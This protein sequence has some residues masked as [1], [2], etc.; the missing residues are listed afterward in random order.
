MV[1]KCAYSNFSKTAIEVRTV[2]FLSAICTNSALTRI[3]AVQVHPPIYR[4]DC[5][6]HHLHRAV[7]VASPRHSLKHY[8]RSTV[9]SPRFL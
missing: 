9:S 1:Q 4:G 8:S 6:L 7:I 5:T 2:V 3:G